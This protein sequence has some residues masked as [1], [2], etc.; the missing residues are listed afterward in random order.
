MTETTKRM[1]T[2]AKSKASATKPRLPQ[3]RETSG[4][5]SARHRADADYPRW[6]ARSSAGGR[7]NIPTK[8]RLRTRSRKRWSFVDGPITAN[9]MGVHYARGRAYKDVPALQHHARYRS[10]QN[11]SMPACGSRSRPRGSWALTQARHRGVRYRALRRAVHGA[12]AYFADRITQ[13]SI[14]L[15]EW[16]DWSN[17]TTPSDQNNWYHLGLSRPAGSMAG[18]IAATT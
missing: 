18:S 11:G 15:G 5:A 4:A 13:Q 17:P 7:A 8:Y 12:R 10:Y 9:P 1:P 14:R 2:R 6:R 16:M 3:R